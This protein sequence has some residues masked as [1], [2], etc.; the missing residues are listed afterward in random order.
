MRS[1][2]RALMLSSLLLTACGSGNETPAAATPD[3]AKAQTAAAEPAGVTA[4][5]AATALG[6]DHLQIQHPDAAF[7]LYRPAAGRY[8][9]CNP[10]RVQ[11]AFLPASTFK[12]ANALIGL[13]TGAVRDEHELMKWDGRKR[14]VLAWNQDT[15]LASGMR[16]STIWFYQAMA[17]RIGA[18]RM[19]E[20][21][22]RLGY[23]NGDIGADN[24]IDHF[25]L[26]GALRISAIEQV[27]FLDR[28]RRHALPIGERSQATAIHI[29]E[30]DRSGD[31]SGDRWV[32]RAKSGA[33]VP[34]DAATGDVVQGEDALKQ[35]GSEPVGWFVGWIERDA[36][37]GGD[38]VFAFNLR[39]RDSAD[40]ALREPLTRELLVAN[41][42]LPP[43]PVTAAARPGSSDR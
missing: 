29:L 24:T 18:A 41:G 35:L 30:R 10:E 31:G 19:R 21:V 6:C 13:E 1:R 27:D 38:A 43:A 42:V 15:D 9:A 8:L 36:A 26:D 11:R 23:G 20:W 4:T 40:M 28:L 12:V 17:R 33:A 25:W 5:T 22:G 34:I 37:H 39:L 3:A 7:L 14:A 16:N 2:I 32:L